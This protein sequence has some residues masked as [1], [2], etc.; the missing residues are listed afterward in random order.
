MATMGVSWASTPHSLST[1]AQ[2]TRFEVKADTPVDRA[3]QAAVEDIVRRG[4]E[5]FQL[6]PEHAAVGVL[7]LLTGRLALVRPDAID[8]AASVP[9]IGILLAWFALRPDATAPI[10]A[11]TRHALGLMIKQSDNAAA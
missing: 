1:M 8:Y 7:D 5:K 10:D 9:K 2:Q 4:R 6:E 3:L 11:E